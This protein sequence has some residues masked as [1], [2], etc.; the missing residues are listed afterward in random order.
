MKKNYYAWVMVAMS[1]F[2][3]FVS[4]GMIS[5]SVHAPYFIEG[6]LTNAENSLLVSLRTFSGVFATAVCGVYYK[7]LS[8]KN[9]MA[10]GLLFGAISYSL[11]SIADVFWIYAVAA[12]FSGVCFGI[13]SSVPTSILVK[14]WFNKNR[15]L[16][17]GITTASSGL[18]S[19]VLPQIVKVLTDAFSFKTTLMIEAILFVVVAVLTFV[20]VVDNPADKG[21][22]PYGG[23]VENTE[24][25][26][27]KS[28]KHF[29]YLP[30]EL[31]PTKLHFVIL[32]LIFFLIGCQLYATWNHMSLLY[33][34]EGIDM[35]IVMSL[36]SIA[37]GALMVGKMVF[38]VFSDKFNGKIAYIVFCIVQV[39][40]M[41]ISCFAA[42]THS[43][44]LGIIGCLLEG[45]AAVT[46]TTGM[47]TICSELYPNPEE[48]K[49]KLVTLTVVYNAG[50]FIFSPIFGI[51][52]DGVGS[53]IPAF[54]MASIL[55]I[56]TIILIAILY[57]GAKKNA[58]LS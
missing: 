33:S 50:G 29:A 43:L 23:T 8:L 28:K 55:G 54:I 9:G 26:N 51:I 35:T 16:A 2:I 27:A 36:I 19:L 47:S 21:L 30:G 3:C 44:P 17:F 42:Y 49:N 24:E 48:Y 10:L 5:N 41:F 57:S 46:A 13:A 31:K 15:S 32:C 20:L 45:G 53:Y 40:G 1:C 58:E 6:G 39:V 12:L 22:E 14:N 25:S 11:Y 7:K 4:I 37:G 56:V 34:T 52:A 38:G 18:T